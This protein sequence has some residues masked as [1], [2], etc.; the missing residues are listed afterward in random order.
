MRDDTIRR[1]KRFLKDRKC[2]AKFEWMVAQAHIP[3]DIYIERVE[4]IFAVRR[5]A[6]MD[7]PFWKQ[8]AEDWESSVVIN[9]DSTRIKK[10]TSEFEFKYVIRA[11][12][13]MQDNGKWLFPKRSFGLFGNKSVPDAYKKCNIEGLR[14]ILSQI[15]PKNENKKENDMIEQEFEIIDLGKKVRS[16]MSEKTLFVN[17]KTQYARLSSDLSKEINDKRM[18][19]CFL[20][21]SKYTNELSIVFC[22]DESDY[23]IKACTKKDKNSITINNKL[24]IE[25]LS[26]YYG[27]SENGFHISTTGNVSKNEK[28]IMI[29][30]LDIK[31]YEEYTD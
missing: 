17:I 13:M 3:F 30:L 1:F 31:Q 16:N 12:R 5:I 2:T 20:Q 29:K 15:C 8:V 9:Q 19:W 24:L 14:D 22:E 23:T 10:L 26:K 21:K 25:E 11:I 18:Y 27:V 28:Y 6:D 4:A 7:D